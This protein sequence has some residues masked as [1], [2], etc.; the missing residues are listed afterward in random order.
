MELSQNQHGGTIRVVVVDDHQLF[1]Q[2]VIGILQTAPDMEVV[3]EADNG[4]D[5]VTVVER[6]SPDVLIM[7]LVM[8]IMNGME[9]TQRVRALGVAPRILILTVNEE[10]RSLYDAVRNGAQGYVIKTVDP[11][12]LLDV[13]RQVAHGEA[14]IPSNLALK[15]LSEMSRAKPANESHFIVKPLTVREIEVLRQIGRGASNR[16]IAKNLHIS[17]STA[18]SYTCKILHK[19]HVSNRVQASAYA[20]R[21]GLL[22]TATTNDD[23]R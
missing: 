14:V 23:L 16:D 19:L 10:E 20:V 21:E 18:R 15:I 13:I 12:D 11:D 2:G 6:V 4:R 8:P 17:E 22:E 1:R 7:D 5:A 9:A 3:G